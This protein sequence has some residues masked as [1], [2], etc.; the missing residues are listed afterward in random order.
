MAEKLP[1]ILWAYRT[2][3]RTPTGETLFLLEF[4]TDAVIPV[5]VGIATHRTMNFNSG[6][7]EEGLKN[8]L[9]FLEEKKE[10]QPLTSTR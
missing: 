3:V 7:N 10:G 8:S 2:T 9:N 6:K 1:S 5:E 4:G